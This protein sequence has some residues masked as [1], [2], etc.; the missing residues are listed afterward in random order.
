[1]PIHVLAEIANAEQPFQG[2]G[3][4]L[5]TAISDLWHKYGSDGNSTFKP[6]IGPE[7]EDMR[8]PARANSRPNRDNVIKRLN[9]F[10]KSV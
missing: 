6:A 2:G 5:D 4:D 3:Q 7:P 8:S 1:M 10:K 9:K